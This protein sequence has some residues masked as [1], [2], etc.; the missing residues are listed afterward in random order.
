VKE[1]FGGRLT[2]LLPL[3]YVLSK[4]IDSSS[5]SNNSSA[6][7]EGVELDE[8]SVLLEGVLDGLQESSA[9]LEALLK[10][11]DLDE[12]SALLEGYELDEMPA[13]SALDEPPLDSLCPVQSDW[14]GVGTTFFNDFS[15]LLH[16]FA[17]SLFHQ[18]EHFLMTPS[19]ADAYLSRRA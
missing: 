19:A 1:N 12:F 15:V 9:L 5:S 4:Q 10:G 18:S 7:S 14:C 16:L 3:E 2:T 6:L 17:D 13:G 8:G 11:D